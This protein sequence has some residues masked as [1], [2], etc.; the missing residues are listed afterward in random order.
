[1]CLKRR[2]CHQPTLAVL[3]RWINQTSSN[4]MRPGENNHIAGQYVFHTANVFNS[5]AFATVFWQ[6][7]ARTGANALRLIDWTKH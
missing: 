7:D 2:H 3:P 5:P 1:M 4:V 6:Q